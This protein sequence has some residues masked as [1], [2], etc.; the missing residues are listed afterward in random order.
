MTLPNLVF[1]ARSLRRFRLALKVLAKSLS[2]ERFDLRG[3][4]GLLQEATAGHEPPGH[5]IA[6]RAARRVEHWQMRPEADRLIGYVISAKH[7]GS[8]PNIDKECVDWVRCHEVH[9]R[10]GKIARSQRVVAQIFEYPPKALE[11]E[12]IVFNNEDDSHQFGI[13]CEFGIVITPPALLDLK[14]C[15]SVNPRWMKRFLRLDFLPDKNLDC[16][17]KSVNP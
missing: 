11:N 2:D 7:Q 1:G 16:F 17:Q 15:V 8:E 13:W 12:S 10:S 14:R 6:K 4:I 3:R 5:L 9:K